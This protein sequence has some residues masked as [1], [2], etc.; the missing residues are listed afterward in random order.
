LSVTAGVGVNAERGET[1]QTV[2]GKLSLQPGMEW[3]GQLQQ[4]PDVDWNAVDNAYN[5]WDY[6]KEGLT[7]KQQH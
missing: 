6:Q 1:L 3:L 7:P 4:R 5:D 2:V